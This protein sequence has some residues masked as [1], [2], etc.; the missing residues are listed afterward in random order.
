MNIIKNKLYTPYKTRSLKVRRFI[1]GFNFVEPN[2]DNLPGGFP[3]LDKTGL[4]KEEGHLLNGIKLAW[5]TS[6]GRSVFY[7]TLARRTV[8]GAAIITIALLGR[9]IITT[10]NN[11]YA[12]SVNAATVSATIK[13]LTKVSAEGLEDIIES[14][15]SA[16][17]NYH[18]EN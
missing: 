14:T 8:L 12:K 5:L 7:R 3:N 11:S 16:I 18:A 4:T 17:F 2:W 6:A 1:A 10:T 15:R 13:N 9:S